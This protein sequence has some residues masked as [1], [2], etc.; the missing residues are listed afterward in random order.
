MVIV[1]FMPQG[2]SKS[3]PRI[4]HREQIGHKI[5]TNSREQNLYW[6]SDSCSA[7]QEIISLSQNAKVHHR[8]HNSPPIDITFSQINPVLKLTPHFL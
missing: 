4:F 3:T 2:Y 1:S 6:K 7:G 8:I 5:L